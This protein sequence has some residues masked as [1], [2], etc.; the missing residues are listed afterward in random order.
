MNDLDDGRVDYWLGLI[1][2]HSPSS[3]SVLEVGCAHGVLLRQLKSRGHECIGVEP[4]ERTAEWVRENMGLDIRAGLFPDIDLP[5][6]DLFLS[7]DVIE[8]SP[9]PIAFMKGAAQLLGP[10]GVAIF[11]TPIDRYDYQPPFGKMFDLVFDDLEHLY[12]FTPR[13]LRIL[14]EMAGL[15]TIA[16]DSWRLAHE[17][18]VLNKG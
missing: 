7:F 11:Q 16:E 14:V 5:K 6:C 10:D 3:R 9:D 12:I 8:H 17:I 15:L 18:V 2:R 1:E 4:D 13:S